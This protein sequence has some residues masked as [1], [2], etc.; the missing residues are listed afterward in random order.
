MPGENNDSERAQRAGAPAR[1]PSSA[2]ARGWPVGTVGRSERSTERG[3]AAAVPNDDEFEPFATGWEDW[4]RRKMRSGS[5]RCGRVRARNAAG[6]GAD[7]AGPSAPT[8]R[9]LGTL[10]CAVPSREWRT[11]QGCEPKQKIALSS[12]GCA[13]FG[14]GEQKRWCFDDDA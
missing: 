1:A 2:R 12:A 5:T 7:T 9:Q 3:I 4:G 6:S 13:F 11:A 14:Y 8:I 10:R